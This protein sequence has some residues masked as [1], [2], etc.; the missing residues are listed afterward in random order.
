MYLPLILGE[1]VD[2]AFD[3]LLESMAFISKKLPRLVI[4][5]V[6]RWRKTQGEGIDEAAVQRAL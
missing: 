3:K 2:A 1:G 4:D 6:M 5:L